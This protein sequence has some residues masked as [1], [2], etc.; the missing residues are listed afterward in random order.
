MTAQTPPPAGAPRTPVQVP[1]TPFT[2]RPLGV[3]IAV[4]GLLLGLGAVCAAVW[5]AFGAE[6]RAEF[7]IFQRSTLAFLGALALASG[8][9]LGRSRVVVRDDGLTVVNGYRTH[10]V[11][12]GDVVAVRMRRGAP[13]ASL[14]REDG[15]VTSLMGIQNS[16]GARAET[17]VRQL[18]AVARARHAG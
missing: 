13:W 15:G 17:A 10:Q 8:H 18:R 2:L 11:A 9:A 14:Q 7:T 16:D 12:W 5:V 3:R 1:P 4:Y 6:V